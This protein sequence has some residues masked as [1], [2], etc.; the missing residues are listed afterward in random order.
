MEHLEGRRHSRQTGHNTKS[1]TKDY[2]GS[3]IG[4]YLLAHEKAGGAISILPVVNRC[5]GNIHG[6]G[7]AGSNKANQG[8]E[9]PALCSVKKGLH[10]STNIFPA[11]KSL[12]SVGVRDTIM[13]PICARELIIPNPLFVVNRILLLA[14]RASGASAICEGG[15]QAFP[16]GSCPTV[17]SGYS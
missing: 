15:D 4:A 6:V 8:T 3:L 16:K 9:Y 17:V 10:A 1:E 2:K 13:D 11:S 7:N 14:H 12:D 5:F